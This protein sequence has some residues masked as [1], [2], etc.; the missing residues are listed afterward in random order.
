MWTAFSGFGQLLPS[1]SGDCSIPLQRPNFLPAWLADMESPPAPAPAHSTERYICIHGHFY[2]PPREN[3][4]LGEIETQPSAA[5]YHDWNARITAECY[6]PNTAAR[7]VT[8]DNRIL[9]IRNNFERI[10]FNFG[11]TLISWLEDHSP[12]VYERILEADRKSLEERGGHGNALAQAY[13]HTILPLASARDK[14]TQVLWGLEDFRRRF[15]RDPEGMWLPETAVDTETLS[16]LADC[17]LRFALLAPH[18]ASRFRGPETPKGW[19]DCADTEI[20]PTRAYTCSLPNGRSIALFFYDGPISRAVAFED[21]LNDGTRMAKRLSEAY[22]EDRAWAQLIHVA[23]DGETYG[24]HHRYGE[25]ALAYALYYIKSRGQAMLTNYGEFLE[26]HPPRAEVEIRERTSWSC[27]HGIERW[28]ADCGCST[29]GRPAWNQR[30]RAPLRE[31]L[32]Q[33]KRQLDDIY[34]RSAGRMLLDPWKTRDEY[35]QLVLDRSSIA[36][37]EFLAAR[38]R[39]ELSDASLT[40][41]LR[42]LEMQHH[43]MLMFTSCGWFFDELSGL[44]A[45]QNLQYA[46][47]ALQL[48]SQFHPGLEREFLRAL[49]T[50]P[51]N[52]YK[53][54]REVWDK[55]VHPSIVDLSRVIAHFSISH[56]YHPAEG[57]QRLFCYEIEVGGAAMESFGQTALGVSQVRAHSLLDGS[58]HESV[59]AVLHFGGHDFHCALRGTLD[60]AGYAELCDELFDTFKSRSMTEV[61]RT[62]DRRFDSRYYT[63]NDLFTEERQRMLGHVTRE[64]FRRF[65]SVMDLI[66]DENRKLMEYVKELGAPLPRGFTA[67]A[68]QALSFRIERA[69]ERYLENGNGED[70]ADLAQEGKQWS[71]ALASSRVIQRLQQALH[72]LVERMRREPS[73]LLCREMMNLLDVVESLGTQ[74]DLWEAQNAVF[75]LI[76][77]LPPYQAPYGVKAASS[78]AA[79]PLGSTDAAALPPA[80]PA[81]GAQL[82]PSASAPPASPVTP[83]RELTASLKALV[84]RLRIVLESPMRRPGGTRGLGPLPSAPITSSGATKRTS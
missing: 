25:M 41:L 45:V 33:F 51:S 6:G 83:G 4:W 81:A 65:Q 44:E 11:P 58:S 21:L 2:Q 39:T 14:R 61:V 10:S 38:A 78:P 7:I 31:A 80:A 67:A 76:H 63:L 74:L 29:G 53:D 27:S 77:G 60:P 17:G 47:R 36:A 24:H 59:A 54:G 16:V 19:K 32:N 43:G 69:I 50:A 79:P 28:R 72:N 23:T 20:D 46:S 52:V 48:A 8:D 9:D 30:W 84:L 34:E 37:R 5:P 64:S 13:N 57:K 66:Y 42:L 56:L 62:L 35:I 73:D 22:R 40:D 26:R 18:Q 82:A 3:P 12:E 71:I 1:P 15:Q 75:R 70:I 55:C 49:G 68:E